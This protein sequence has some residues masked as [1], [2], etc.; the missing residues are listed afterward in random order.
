MLPIF[1]VLQLAIYLLFHV[2]ERLYPSHN[3]QRPPFFGLY[4][5]LLGFFAIFWLRVTFLLWIEFP[6][7][8]MK[9]FSEW[10]IEGGG[11]YLVYSFSNYWFHRFKHSNSI[12]WKYLHTFHHS[13]SHME[14]RI[15]FYRHPVEVVA[16]SVLLVFLGKILLDVSVVAVAF[17]LL[18]EGGLEVFH[19]SNIR[20]DRRFRWVGYIIQTPE[21]HL[22]H[23]QKGV[24]R[25]NYGPFLWDAVFGTARFPD[26]EVQAL[27]FCR[28]RDILGFLVFKHK[29]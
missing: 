7:I 22:V 8:G 29:E 27:G 2:F 5:V 16:N 25:Y 6:A 14:A 10:W 20:L 19:H 26:D 18:I 13:P 17:A 12:A 3:H 11:F 15:A 1:M 23:H 4:W 24:H 21:M 9:I 28:S